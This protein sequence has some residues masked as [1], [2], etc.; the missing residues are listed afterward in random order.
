[1]VLK[2]GL[3]GAAIYAWLVVVIL[4]NIWLQR[5]ALS[6]MGYAVALIGIFIVH[7]ASPYL[8]HPLGIGFLLL[9]YSMFVL[10]RSARPPLVTAPLTE[11]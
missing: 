8:N 5:Q 11:S 4:K 7:I 10:K 9:A 6:A 1:M 2:I 3:I